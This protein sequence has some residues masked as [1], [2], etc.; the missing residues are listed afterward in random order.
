MDKAIE[1]PI[2]ECDLKVQV[3]TDG[4]WLHFG[5]YAAIHVHNTLGQTGVVI[6]GN[7][8]KWCLAREEQANAKPKAD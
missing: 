7:I 6:G 3:G 1:L 5:Q 2:T 8:N 4:V